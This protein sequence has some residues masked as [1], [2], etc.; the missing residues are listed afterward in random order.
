M[1]S[2]ARTQGFT[3]VELLIV[4]VVIAILA[5]ITIV[6]YSGIQSRARDSS[7]K[8]AINTVSKKLKAYKIEN[9]ETLPAT[10][11]EI[12]ITDNTSVTY[13]YW[14]NTNVTPNISCA[15][16]TSGDYSYQVASSGDVV[17]GSCIG[18]TGGIPA[19][20]S[21]PAGY[22]LVPGNSVFNTQA[23][24]VMKYEAKNSG[25]VAVSAATGTPWT[26]ITQPAARAAAAAACTGCHLITKNEW[27]TIAHNAMSLNDNWVSGTV[28][29]GAMV[30]GHKDGAPANS[31]AASTDDSD[32]YYGTLNS[33]ANNLSA[34]ERRTLTLTNGQ[35][36]WDIGGNVWEFTD[37]I[38]DASTPPPGLPTD[39]L[40]NFTY[41]EW[42]DANVVPGGFAS[43]FPGYG[44]PIATS[45]NSIQGL[46]K[47]VT[48]TANTETLAL[49]VGGAYTTGYVNGGLFSMR[50]NSIPSAASASTGFRVVAPT[51]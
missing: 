7:V 3:I 26:S 19:S 42:N 49:A 8:Q 21:C 37:N 27:L 28:G 50:L 14:L 47:F 30:S 17:Q 45:W 4:V 34:R 35:V 18:H 39:T 25:G 12:G 36:V 2:W 33:T 20:L 40:N 15:T 48:S 44:N 32:G 16:A 10:L 43:S 22:A 41:K 13:Q 29:T 31:L 23:F 9:S 24:C 11:A 1:K 5:A 38:S 51:Q 6:A 46:G